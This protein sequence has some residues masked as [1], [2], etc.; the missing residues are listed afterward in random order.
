MQEIA[1]VVVALARCRSSKNTFGI[2]VEEKS[3]AQWIADWAFS[4]SENKALK[5]GYDRTEIRGSFAI[6]AD[7]YPGCPHCHASAFFKCGCGKLAC[8]DG[9]NRQL[10]CPWCGTKGEIKGLIESLNIG[11]DR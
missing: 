4:I 9:E 11:N 1:R 6:D 7:R 2:R 10:T 3:K 5:E 8:W